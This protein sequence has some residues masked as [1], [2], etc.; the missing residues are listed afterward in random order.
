MIR[1]EDYVIGLPHCAGR[2]KQDAH[3]LSWRTAVG[4]LVQSDAVPKS[5]TSISSV[6]NSRISG[7]IRVPKLVRERCKH[8]PQEEVE[9]DALEDEKAP[10]GAA[11]SCAS[12]ESA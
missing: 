6:C 12:S 2:V 8:E 3:L 11:G 9:D 7:S 5:F 1:T 10:A 4:R